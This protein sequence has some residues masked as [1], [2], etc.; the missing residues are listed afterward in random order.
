ML[1]WLEKLVGPV[2]VPWR[3]SS[4]KIDE[5]GA[6]VDRKGGKGLRQEEKG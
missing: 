3:W 5:I 4:W 1:A 2:L 6:G